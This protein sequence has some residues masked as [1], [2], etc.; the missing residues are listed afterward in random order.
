MDLIV[1]TLNDSHT[2]REWILGDT[3][4]LGTTTPVG[5]IH[6]GFRL[7][8]MLFIHIS[9]LFIGHCVFTKLH[10]SIMDLKIVQ[11]CYENMWIGMLLQNWFES[12]LATSHL[13]LCALPTLIFT[14]LC[15]LDVKVSNWFISPFK[16]THSKINK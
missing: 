11:M 5:Q 3:A 15:T 1:L 6:N 13:L 8:L 2:K 16:K 10:T 14:I 4:T 9:F 12:I 7:I